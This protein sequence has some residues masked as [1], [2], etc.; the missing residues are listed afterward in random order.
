[1]GPG[2]DDESQPLKDLVTQEFGF[3]LEGSIKGVAASDLLFMK[4]LWLQSGE[5]ISE[6]AR[7]GN[8][9]P[10][11]SSRL[12]GMDELSDR[13]ARSKDANGF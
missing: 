6:E 4:I 5:W 2:E 10:G 1:M 8:R 12:V 11:I 9:G 3:Y 13:E 7:A